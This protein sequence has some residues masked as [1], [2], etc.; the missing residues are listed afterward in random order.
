MERVD[1]ATVL[2]VFNQS[3]TLELIEKR[4]KYNRSDDKFEEQPLIPFTDDFVTYVHELTSGEPRLILVR[5]GHVIDAG[6][7]EKVTKLDKKFAQKVLK[8]RGY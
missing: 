5:C 2:G 3:Q 4:L 6:I 7:A 8:E 1:N